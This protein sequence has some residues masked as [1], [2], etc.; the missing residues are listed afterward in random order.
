MWL[1]NVTGVACWVVERLVTVSSRSGGQ[2]PRRLAPGWRH[3]RRSSVSTPC[4]N[5]PA[6][7]VGRRS[8][9]R[10]PAA[11]SSPPNNYTLFLSMHH[12]KAAFTPRHT[13]PGNV[14]PGRATCIRIIHI[15]RRTH[16]A[17][18]WHIYNSFMSRSTCIPLYPAT[19]EQQTDDNFVADTRNMLT[20]TSGYKRI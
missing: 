4:R 8:D 6:S 2:A 5:A 19:D 7:V 16:V 20:A 12:R 1:G 14:Y 10:T 9:E 3:Q 17:S 13:S 18:R 15:C 11:L